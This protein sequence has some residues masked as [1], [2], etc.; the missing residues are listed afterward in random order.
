MDVNALA[1][2]LGAAL[3]KLGGAAGETWHMLA[4]ECR[5]GGIA[6]IV[7]GGLLLIVSVL[8]GALLFRA[9]RR[10]DRDDDDCTGNAIPLYVGVAGCIVV[11][12]LVALIKVLTNIPWAFAPHFCLLREL[13]RAAN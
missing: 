8:V 6:C 9:A 2:K 10:I 3:A 7:A 5:A 13:L 12:C 11:G 4:A 1:D